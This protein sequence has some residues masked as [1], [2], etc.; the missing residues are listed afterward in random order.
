MLHPDHSFTYPPLLLVSPSY[1]SYPIHS[2]FSLQKRACLQG[3][4]SCNRTTLFSSYYLDE[5]SQL[6]KK[7]HNKGGGAKESERYSP[8][9]YFKESHKNT[10]LH[11]R[12]MYAEFLIPWWL[13]DCWFRLHVPLWVHV[14]SYHP[15]C[16]QC[17]QTWKPTTVRPG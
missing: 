5:A 7:G 13:P 16:T 6:D 9:F 11:N 3:I 12:N 14:S 1:I 4:S 8:C 17:C 15:E 2:S 10:K